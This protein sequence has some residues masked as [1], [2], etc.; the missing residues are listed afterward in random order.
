MAVLPDSDRQLILMGLMRYWSQL[1]ETISD[2]SK[3]EL[4]SAVDATDQ[5]IENNQASFNAAL[6]AIPRSNLTLAQ[7]TLIFCVVAAFRVSKQFVI[8]LIGGIN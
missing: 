2:L 3:S 8:R 4:K 5:W 7:K 1:F 6:P